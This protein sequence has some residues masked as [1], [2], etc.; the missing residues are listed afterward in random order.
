MLVMTQI[1][2]NG[3]RNA[4]IYNKQT[5]N[6]IQFNNLFIKTIVRRTL[7]IGVAD[8]TDPIRILKPES[9]WLFYIVHTNSRVPAARAKHVPLADDIYKS[10][11]NSAI[12]HTLE[13]DGDN[14]PTCDNTGYEQYLIVADAVQ[15]KVRLAGSKLTC[16]SALSINSPGHPTAMTH[17]DQHR[18]QVHAQPVLQYTHRYIQ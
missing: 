2:L 8:N 3:C 13:N 17:V 10:R 16:R 9:W 14:S 15:T 1:S 4:T 7:L 6:P 12:R 11:S 18:R 5:A